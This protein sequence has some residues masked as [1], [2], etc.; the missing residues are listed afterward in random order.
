MELKGS[1]TIAFTKDSGFLST[2][3]DVGFCLLGYCKGVSKKPLA[4]HI[5]SLGTRLDNSVLNRGE[6]ASGKRH[7]PSLLQMTDVGGD[8]L[9]PFSSE[10][11][12]WDADGIT[13]YPICSFG[14]GC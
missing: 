7:C 2:V 1:S 13:C 9:R 10:V 8:S 5:L 4:E 6:K 14:H 12:C 3:K 11:C